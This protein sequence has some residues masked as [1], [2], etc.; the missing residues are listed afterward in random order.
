MR[1]GNWWSKRSRA[2]VCQLAMGIDLLAGAVGV[3]R[4][5][6]GG[7]AAACAGPPGDFCG[8]K[9]TYIT[10]TGLQIIDSINA[11][12]YLTGKCITGER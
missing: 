5:G 11:I 6:A 9:C 4:A 1:G 3:C 12:I 8:V 7:A 10:K 2:L